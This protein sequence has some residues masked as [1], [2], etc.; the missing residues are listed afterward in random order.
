M[1]VVCC[2][3][4]KWSSPFVTGTPPPPLEGFSLTLCG[5]RVVLFGG[6]SEGGVDI[7]AVYYFHIGQ[8][9]SKCGNVAE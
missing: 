2:L 3:S 5:N 9:V 7:N 8:N 4:G 6:K 1:C